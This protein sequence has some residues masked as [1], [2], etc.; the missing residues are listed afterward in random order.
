LGDVIDRKISAKSQKFNQIKWLNKMHK[1]IEI[2]NLVI[3]SENG[4]ALHCRLTACLDSHIYYEN[5]KVSKEQSPEQ[6]D[7]HGKQQHFG[8]TRC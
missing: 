1:W 2:S 5:V 7:N 6:N 3:P 4:S 8:W